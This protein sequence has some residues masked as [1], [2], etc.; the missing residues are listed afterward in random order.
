MLREEQLSQTSLGRTRSRFDREKARKYKKRELSKV[1]EEQCLSEEG[2]LTLS[3][4]S[5]GKGA[6]LMGSRKKNKGS[7]KEEGRFP[8]RLLEERLILLGT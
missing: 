8:L 7:R 6:S 2:A 1:W 5:V 4:G 3:K